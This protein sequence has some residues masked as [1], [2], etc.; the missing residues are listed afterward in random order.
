MPWPV[1]GLLALLLAGV[2]A[3]LLLERGAY[4][5]AS[6]SV[7]A[8]VTATVG[9]LV[10]I[11]GVPH[12]LL[13]LGVDPDEALP[14]PEGLRPRRRQRPWR[15]DHHPVAFVSSPSSASTSSSPG[16]SS[17]SPSRRWSTTRRCSAWPAPARAAVRRFSWLVGSCFAALSGMLLAPSLAL[18][19]RLLTLL[20]FFAFGAAAVGGVLQPAADLRRRARPRRRASLL[21]KVLGEMRHQGPDPGPPGQ[22]AVPRP[23]RGAADHPQAQA[24]GTG[25]SGGAPA[26][27]ATHLQPARSSLAATAVGARRRAGHPARRRRQ[28]ADLH[29]RRWPT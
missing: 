11:Q 19:A 10:L 15:A 14:A 8:R 25:R 2:V 22:P 18:D 1:A 24:G 26:A 7:A 27:A 28:A 9:L 4:V 16:P 17:G 20:V 5:L 3:G 23:V 21:T 12:R 29:H 13:R 6:V